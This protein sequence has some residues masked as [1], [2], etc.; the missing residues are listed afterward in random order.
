MLNVY[1][2][3]PWTGV[4]DWTEQKKWRT[5]FVPAIVTLLPDRR[6][7]DVQPPR[8]PASHL[9]AMMAHILAYLLFVCW[10][11]NSGKKRFVLT[12]CSWSVLKGSQGKKSRQGFE[13]ETKRR[14]TCGRQL[15]SHP[16]K[17]NRPKNGTAHRRLGPPAS[18][19]NQEIPYRHVHRPNWWR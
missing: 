3:M 13:V 6:T 4:P 19:N 9:S 11:R 18:V 1:N 15:F 2:T 10:H 5:F 17:T 8:V 12:Y 7:E 14:L 16:V